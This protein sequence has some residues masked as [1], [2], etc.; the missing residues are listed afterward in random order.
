M[1]ATSPGGRPDPPSPAQR[2]AEMEALSAISTAA[3][4][5]DTPE[6]F[7]EQAFSE[8]CGVLGAACAQLLLARGEEGALVVEREAGDTGPWAVA[9][10]QVAEDCAR[11]LAVVVRE[12]EAPGPPGEATGG[13][14]PTRDLRRVAL[15]LV[16]QHGALG[17]MALLCPAPAPGPAPM[18]FLNSLSLQLHV[19]LERTSLWRETRELLE[20]R[21]E[22]LDAIITAQE[23]ERKRVAREL[24]DATGQVLTSLLLGLSSLER[25]GVPPEAG[26]LLADLQNLAR[27]L[28]DTVRSLCY[29]LMPRA[30]EEFGL[31]EALKS[32]AR[33][34]S[35][36]HGIPVEVEVAGDCPASESW[37]V[38]LALYRIVQEAL[39]NVV[40]H[41]RASRVSV[42]LTCGP[43]E[44]TVVVED[45]G[46]G[47]EVGEGMAVAGERPS[48][49][50]FGMRERAALL[51]GRVAIES[52][53]GAGTTVYARLPRGGGRAGREAAGPEGGGPAE[54]A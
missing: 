22:L 52:A 23:D 53:P 13:E 20:M 14:A 36:R 5:L 29:E 25:A 43:G 26:P 33:D 24:H 10:R 44:E 12:P 38:Q 42:T 21:R 39:A 28:L 3:L 7:L 46:V 1:P 50:L 51:G 31:A 11:R 8:V 16:S 18:V 32:Q 4:R 2:T 6:Q 9:L 19:G 49:G 41:A 45:D 34:F 37:E 30:L 47:F 17:V 35:R 54:N 48:L 15:P 27:G 40:R